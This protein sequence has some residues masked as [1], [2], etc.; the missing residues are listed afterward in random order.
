MSLPCIVHS[1]GAPCVLCRQS[2][3]SLPAQTHPPMAPR[4]P[5]VTARTGPAS[6]L[7]IRPSSTRS[8]PQIEA[9]V[10]FFA[11]IAAD[12]FVLPALLLLPIACQCCADPVEDERLPMLWT[13]SVSVMLGSACLGWLHLPGHHDMVT[14]ALFSLHV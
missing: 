3:R 12:L 4:L 9:C 2:S 6:S 13:A 7:K 11:F 14:L 1:S 5:Q 8:P 10:H